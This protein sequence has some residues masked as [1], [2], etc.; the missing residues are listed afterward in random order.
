MVYFIA[1]VESKAE[2]IK[3]GVVIRRSRNVAFACSLESDV[4]TTVLVR[5]EICSYE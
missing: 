4:E 5:E 1:W 2:G 3:M